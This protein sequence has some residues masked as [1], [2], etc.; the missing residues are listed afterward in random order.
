M[1]NEEH[2]AQ[3]RALAGSVGSNTARVADAVV[4]G[5]GAG[6]V[7]AREACKE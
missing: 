1:D 2:R 3:M 6:V 7:V 5:R 4:A